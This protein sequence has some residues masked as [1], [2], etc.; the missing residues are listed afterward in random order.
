[1]TLTPVVVDWSTVAEFAL[2]VAVELALN[3]E[4]GIG[5]GVGANVGVGV[6]VGALVGAGVGVAVGA[7]DGEGVDTGA[8]TVTDAAVELTAAPVLSVT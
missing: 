2:T 8:F 6:S 7:G 1:V 4:A 5:A 3:P